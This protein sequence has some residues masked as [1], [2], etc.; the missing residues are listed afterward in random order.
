MIRVLYQ[1]IKSVHLL[2]YKERLDKD[3]PYQE[4]YMPWPIK[5]SAGE[6]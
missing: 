5:K 1:D 6:N 4:C 3:V 2:K